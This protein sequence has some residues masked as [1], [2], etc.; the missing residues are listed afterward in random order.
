MREDEFII[1][2]DDFFVTEPIEAVP[3][4]HA[5]PLDEKLR[6]THGGYG[7]ALRLAQRRLAERDVTAPL[8]WTLHIPVHVVRGALRAILEALT[9]E[10]RVL[11]EW[12]T[13]YGNLIG[14]TGEQHEDCKV[15]GAKGDL[16]ARPF[17]SSHDSSFHRVLPRL[18][19]LFPEPC[20]YEVVT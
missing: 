10:R 18:R 17:L 19:E 20:R 2:N 9:P 15:L 11:P 13:M 6:T 7:N 5:G 1:F 16:D 3:S 4:W 14:A 12:R 8:A